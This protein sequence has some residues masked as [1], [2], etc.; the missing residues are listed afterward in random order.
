M[1]KSDFMNS[2]EKFVSKNKETFMIS[3]RKKKKQ[4]QLELQR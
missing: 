3:L 2:Q 4:K 1:K